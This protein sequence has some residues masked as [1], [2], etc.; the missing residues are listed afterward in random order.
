MIS[1]IGPYIGDFENEIIAF[2]PYARWLYEVVDADHTF[3]CTH[4]NR[5][6]MYEFI[7]PDNII[8]VGS[9]LSRDEFGQIGYIHKSFG[10]KDFNILLKIFKDNIADKILCGK[11]EIE[12]YSLGYLK[13]TPPCSIYN[14]I[15]ERINVPD[16]VSIP[17]THKNRVVFIPCETENE[18][19]IHEIYNILKKR[20]DCIVIG[21]TK[22]YLPEE[23]VIFENIDYFQNVYKYIIK[24]LD[25]ARVVICPE[26]YWTTLCCLQDVPVF[27]WGPNPGIY[28]S[29]GIYNFNNK[30]SL[31][32]AADENTDIDTIIRMFEYFMEKE[33]I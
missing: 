25:S 20:Y 27:S 24:Y 1:G 30:K 22:I 21:D 4:F 31:S 13:S 23:N 28:H 17:D 9:N 7:H 8:H 32:F 18:E 29:D 15:F 19:K 14:K 11:K 2:R 3:I 5:S 16:D 10:K 12:I 6:F 33:N 26:S